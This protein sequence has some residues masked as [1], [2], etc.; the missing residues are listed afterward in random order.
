M[1][2]DKTQTV[3]AWEKEFQFASSGTEG[4][5]DHRAS[6]SEGTAAICRSTIAWNKTQKSEKCNSSNYLL[7]QLVRWFIRPRRIH[8]GIHCRL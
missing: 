1:T 2:E 6:N 5:P 4:V 7:K 8:N 3:K